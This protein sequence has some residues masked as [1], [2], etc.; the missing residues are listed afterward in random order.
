MQRTVFKL[1]LLKRVLCVFTLQLLFL[2][3]VHESLYWRRR[4][5][6][7]LLGSHE[8]GDDVHWHREHDGAVLLGA[9]VVQRLEVAELQKQKNKIT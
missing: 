5:R 9:D 6:R 1:E 3:L 4:R 7:R 8:V 2:L